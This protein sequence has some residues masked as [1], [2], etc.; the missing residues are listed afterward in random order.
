MELML[1]NGIIKRLPDPAWQQEIDE[2][3]GEDHLLSPDEFVLVVEQAAQ[4]FA[5]TD[6]TLGK[7]VENDFT[8]MPEGGN[9]M[10]AEGLEEFA[11]K[12]F[13]WADKD[14]NNLLD[15]F[16]LIAVFEQL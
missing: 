9:L 12:V 8:E 5:D 15:K 10:E 4:K 16:E 2:V 14:N 1:S 7:D 6:E 11:S 3:T 13:P